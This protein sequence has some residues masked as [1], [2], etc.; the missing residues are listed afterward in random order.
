MAAWVCFHES[1]GDAAEL[2]ILICNRQVDWE[3][4]NKALFFQREAS[5]IL[6]GKPE[7]KGLI[8][9]VFALKTR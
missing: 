4:I 3:K 9:S 2:T 1:K 7:R 5:L 8:F 6:R